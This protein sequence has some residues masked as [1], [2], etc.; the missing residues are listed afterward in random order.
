MDKNDPLLEKMDEDFFL[1]LWGVKDSAARLFK[2][3]GL[4]PEQAFIIEMISRG[5]NHPKAISEAM[6][7]DPSLLSHHLSRLEDAGLIERAL[8]PD[9]RRRTRLKLT[10]KGEK[11]LE[12]ARESWRLYTARVLSLFEPEEIDTL[13][14]FLA[15]LLKAQE[16]LL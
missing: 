3:L 2:P 9:D 5:L 6:Q 12:R 8:D 16:E 4:R 15:R 13:R 11:L 10:G 7:L 1:F 14:S